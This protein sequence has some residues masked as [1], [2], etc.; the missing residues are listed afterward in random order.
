MLISIF[1]FGV[2]GMT[3]QAAFLREMLATFRGSELTIGLALFFWLLWTSVGSGVLGRLSS[4]TTDPGTLFHHLLPWYGL[5]GYAGVA[6]IG[7]VPFIARLT[8]GELVPY[9]IQFIAAATAFLPFNMLGGFLFTAGIRSLERNG[10]RAAGRVYMAEALGSTL[11]GIAVSLAFITFLDN[12]EV[13]LIC[14]V[15]S[16]VGVLIRSYRVRRYGLLLW[17]VVTIALTIVLVAWYGRARAYY[18]S[19]QT[20]LEER[21]TR[22]GRLRVTKRAEQT[23][24]YSDAF[25]L[26]SQPDPETSENTAHIPMLAA[27]NPARVLILGGGPGGVIDEVVKYRSVET[28]TCV[29]LDPYLFELSRRH[30]KEPWRQDGR[31]G[32][33]FADGR[34]FLASTDRR[35]DVIIIN[36]PPPLSGVTNRYYTAEFF[37]LCASRLTPEGIASFALTGEEN[38]IPYDLA[39]F[40]ASIRATLATSFPSV[41]VLPGP[42]YRFIAGNRSGLVDSLSWED[43]VDRRKKLGIETSYV[44]DYFLQFIMSPMRVEFLNEALG[45]VTSPSINSDTTPAGYF[46]CTVVQGNLD[47]SLIVSTASRFARPGL[48]LA[49]LAAVLLSI[50]CLALIPGASAYRRSVLAAIMSVGMTEI[51]LEVL[52]IMAYQSVFGY[53]YGRIALLVGCYMA[54]LSLGAFYGT[55]LAERGKAGIR[56]LASVQ[57]GIAVIPVVW[58]ILL[59]LSTISGGHPLLEACFYIF[60]GLSGIAGGLQFPV[61][62]FLYRGPAASGKAGPGAVYAFDLAGSS[63]GALLTGAL[64][65]PVLGMT[66]TLAFFTVLNA[67]TTSILLAKR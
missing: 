6:V 3:A 53:L 30:I 60:T 45:S 25:T 66:Y 37:K 16:V 44:R 47:N 40:F 61:A 28:I 51:S 23:T 39:S 55:G 10:S 11:A 14:P 5:L 22:Y 2:V 13:A 15:L 8:P 65:I 41:T 59:M 57:A 63:T 46:L 33:V 1:I 56:T 48:L 67:V 19:G 27:V 49:L 20:L 24:F 62:D 52:A 35:F 17:P 50:S 42:R 54:G 38:Y 4:K 64:L 32:T 26:F 58:M 21:D 34:A 9:D 18:Y 29:E 36:M 31:V 43:I 12:N 7:G